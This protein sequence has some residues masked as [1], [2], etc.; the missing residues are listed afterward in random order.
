M[1]QEWAHDIPTSSMCMYSWKLGKLGKPGNVTGTAKKCDW[2]SHFH[3]IQTVHCW[4]G[5]RSMA[6]VTV[7]KVYTDCLLTHKVPIL[8]E[9]QAQH[10]VGYSSD[11][12]GN[13]VHK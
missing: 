11:R 3:F 7:I 8:P 13:R 9:N 2:I 12:D 10:L 1:I 6:S 5:E 4:S